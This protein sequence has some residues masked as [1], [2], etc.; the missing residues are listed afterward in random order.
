MKN[1]SLKALVE[2][3]VANAP[4]QLWPTHDGKQLDRSA[5][6]TASEV[7]NCVRSTWFAKHALPPKGDGVWG[8]FA[9]GHNVEA[10]VVDQLRMSNSG[11]TFIMMGSDQRSMHWEGQAGTPDGIMT[12][13]DQEH[14]V[15]DI[16]SIHPQTNRK[17]LPKPQ[18]VMQIHQNILLAEKCLDIEIAGGMILY[19]DASNYQTMDEYYI[20]Y[21]IAAM[22]QVTDRA[23]RIH[24]AD[25]PND[26]PAEGMFKSN[27]CKFCPFTANCSDAVLAEN[28]KKSQA[29]KHKKVAKN[30]FN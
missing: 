13:L 21:D 2:Q 30:V 25:K 23:T 29:N 10:W 22:E 6:V 15:F 5:F 3:G 11:A 4:K 27:G 16:K 18:H 9:R 8:Y 26:L 12:T 19:V 1:P 24:E 28:A 20:E 14:Y 7:G 17:F